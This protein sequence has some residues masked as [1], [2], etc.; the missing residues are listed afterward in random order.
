MSRP[1]AM[2][3]IVR[4]TPY[5]YFQVIALLRHAGLPWQDLGDRHMLQFVVYRKNGELKGVAGLE[6][7]GKDGLLR[8]VAISET[9]RGCGI[10]SALVSAIELNASEQGI[11]ALY[12]LT[13]TAADYFARRGYEA[14]CRDEVP[15]LVARSAEF[16]SLC[17]GSAVCMMK[18][19][20]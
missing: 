9:V 13:T 15:D 1:A 7:R 11:H 14:I 8:S 4:A 10:G 12:L 18:A 2:S 6:R 5:D 19:L 20:R 3:E 17:P 16:A